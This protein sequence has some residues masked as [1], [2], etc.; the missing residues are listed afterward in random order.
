MQAVAKTQAIRGGNGMRDNRS[1]IIAGIIP[2]NG[3][4]RADRSN[5]QDPDQGTISQGHWTH[6]H[7]SCAEEAREF[8]ADDTEGIAHRA[9]AIF[10]VRFGLLAKE[11]KQ[12]QA[13]GIA[14]QQMIVNFREQFRHV[15]PA[16]HGLHVFRQKLAALRTVDQTIQALK[17]SR[18]ILRRLRLNRRSRSRCRCRG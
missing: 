18:Q 6:R 7:L 4:E 14:N 12:D 3:Q 11:V 15:A 2:T 8:P 10:A 13:A 9:A 17:H 5:Q 16:I 1:M